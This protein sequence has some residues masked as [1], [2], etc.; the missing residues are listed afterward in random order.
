MLAGKTQTGVTLQTLH[1][2]RFDHGVI[3]DQTPL[4]GFDIPNSGNCTVPELLEV[5]SPKAAEILVNGIRNHL[6]VPPI[7]AIQQSALEDES[8]LI[9][10][11]KITPEDRHIKWNEWDREHISRRDRVLGPL[12]NNAIV[13]NES[14]GLDNSF[15]T[16]RVIF[17]NIEEVDSKE[18]FERFR[19]LPGVPFAEAVPGQKPHIENALYVYSGDGKLLRLR[20]IKVEAQKVNDG[21]RAAKKAQMFSNRKLRLGDVEFY[22]FHNPLF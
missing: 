1:H 15:Q 21:F 10:A 12:W 20:E 8:E 16:R 18:R 3:L 11:T 5:V 7:Q 6:F 22:V 13:A 19:L 9:H 17:T 2:E 4:P 14:D